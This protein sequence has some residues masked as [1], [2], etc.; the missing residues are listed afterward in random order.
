MGDNMTTSSLVNQ[1]ESNSEWFSYK[2]GEL[3]AEQVR[4][5]EIAQD[6][7]TPFYCYSTDAIKWAYQTLEEELRKIDVSICFA[8]KANSNIAV[9]RL[10]AKLGCGMDIVSGGELERVLAAGLPAKSVIFSG[11]GKTRRE[12]KRALEV[13]VQ[14]INVESAA[15]LDVIIEVACLLKTRAPVALRVNPDV[16]AKTHAK[17]TTATKKSKFGIPIAEV[18]AVYSVASKSPELELKGLAVH[19]G[20]QMQDLSPFRHTFST[21]SDLV[22]DLRSQGLEVQHLDLGGGIG[23]S[24]GEK[25]GPDVKEYSKIIAET[26]G[27]LGCKLTV[28]PG[29]WL[30]GRAGVLVTEVLYLKDVDSDTVVII[31]SGMNDLIRPAL[32]DATHPV[33][34]INEPDRDTKTKHRIVGPICESSDDF[35]YYTGLGKIAAGD[36]V[37]FDCA[38]AYGAAMSSTYNSRD[39][40][41]EVLVEN[42]RYRLIRNRLDIRE[43]LKIEDKGE[44]KTAAGF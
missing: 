5:S 42:D 22:R 36:L 23:I 18:P 21:M 32:Y 14:Q 34:P 43:Q 9:L 16:D 29:R 10:L 13:G 28:E 17:I 1:R 33:I 6:I 15:E 12:I 2:G 26:V 8:V 40:I 20:S 39:L 4:L 19:V 37:A 38:G 24:I 7:P 31:D 35:G 3:H 30:V 25:P 11:I 44:W 41:A 27:D